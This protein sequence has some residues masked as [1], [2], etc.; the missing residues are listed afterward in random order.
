MAAK[1]RER[2]IPA[3]RIHVIPNWCDDETIRPA[4]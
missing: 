1:L 4:A 3:D 2:G